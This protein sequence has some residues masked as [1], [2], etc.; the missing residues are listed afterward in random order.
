MKTY[1]QLANEAI[2]ALKALND[3]DRA[4]QA[5]RKAGR[6]AANFKPTERPL[7]SD[8]QHLELL[9]EMAYFDGNAEEGLDN[10]RQMLG[11]D[12]E[13][14]PLQDVHGYDVNSRKSREAD[15]AFKEAGL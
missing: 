3:V 1:H 15:R 5:S 4:W 9:T 8:R 12:D 6:Y 7:P 14:Y 10:L 11:I 13:G 2:L